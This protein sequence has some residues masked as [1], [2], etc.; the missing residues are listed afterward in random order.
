MEDSAYKYN[1]IKSKTTNDSFKVY[2]N[3]LTTAQPK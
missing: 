1:A 2:R 3:L